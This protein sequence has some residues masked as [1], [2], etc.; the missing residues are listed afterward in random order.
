MSAQNKEFVSSSSMCKENEITSS[1][2]ASNMHHQQQQFDSD[3]NEEKL[4]KGRQNDDRKKGFLSDLQNPTELPE[5]PAD[6]PF[7]DLHR[8]MVANPEM[9]RLVAIAEANAEEMLPPEVDSLHDVL[10]EALELIESL[11]MPPSRPCNEFVSD[12]DHAHYEQRQ[13]QERIP[14][15]E[16]F[17]MLD[18]EKDLC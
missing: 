14:V 3:N 9:A 2:V 5:F 18:M 7:A 16:A 15:P 11:K 6:N 4:P 10:G 13:R 12:E 17:R 8:L 1:T